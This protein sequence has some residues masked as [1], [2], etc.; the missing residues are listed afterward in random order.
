M[1]D[2]MNTIQ[3]TPTDMSAVIQ[4]DPMVAEKVKNAALIRM[5]G[6]ANKRIENLE[7]K[8]AELDPS[9]NGTG[10]EPMPEAVTAKKK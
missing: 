3:I 9:T 6:W 10:E 8:L 4:A 2:D 1:P 5:L 7:A